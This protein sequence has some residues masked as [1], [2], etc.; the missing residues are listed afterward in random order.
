MKTTIK[1]LLGAT[2]MIAFSGT[3][4]AQLIGACPSPA[5]PP[6]CL[7]NDYRNIA[8]LATTNAQ[9]VQKIKVFYDQLKETEN[10]IKTFGTTLAGQ[11]MVSSESVIEK[12]TDNHSVVPMGSVEKM[13]NDVARVVYAGSDNGVKMDAAT[14]SETARTGMAREANVNAYGVSSQSCRMAK[15]SIRKIKELEEAAKKSKDFRGDWLANSQI[16]LETTRISAQKNYLIS[17]WLQQKSSETALESDKTQMPVSTNASYGPAA[18]AKPIDPAWEKNS[19]LQDIGNKIQELLSAAIAATSGGQALDILKLQITDQQVSEQRRDDLLAQLRSKAAEWTRQSGKGSATTIVNTVLSGLTNMDGQLAAL[20]AQPIA[21]LSREFQL[22][23]IDVAKMTSGEI[24]PRQFIG[25]WVDPNKT[26]MA[27][28]M[29]NAMLRG[30]LDPMIESDASND[31]FRQIVTSY[32]DSRLEESWKR[33]L[34]EEAKPLIVETGGLLAGGNERAG[35]NLSDKAAVTAEIQR[36]V[37]EANKLAQEVGTSPDAT[38]KA[39]AAGIVKQ[40]QGYLTSNAQ[41]E[42]ERTTPDTTAGVTTPPRPTTL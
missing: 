37:T 36:L 24:D 17:T 26:K 16:H 1:V 32:N 38:A 30:S 2:S 10:L 41:A 13:S 9:E 11:T 3:A 42:Q 28:D 6:P 23:N 5:S 22:R 7:I 27:L 15:Q 20:R 40:I 34:A 31:Q 33:Q 4:H 18:A 39:E 25:T 12:D 19:Q 35:V 8:K 21:S 14:E 29:A